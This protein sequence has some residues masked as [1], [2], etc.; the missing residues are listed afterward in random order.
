VSTLRASNESSAITMGKDMG[1]V[2][3]TESAR[4]RG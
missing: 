1:G 3:K 4:A 2:V